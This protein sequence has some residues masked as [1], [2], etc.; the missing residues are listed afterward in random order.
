M[1]LVAE[2]P[3]AA[4]DLDQVRCGDLLW[5]IHCTW[6]DGKAGLVTAATEKQLTVQY[7]PGIGNITNHFIIPVSE[8]A[9]GEWQVRWS[10]DLSDIKKFILPEDSD[11][12]RDIKPENGGESAEKEESRTEVKICVGTGTTD[13]QEI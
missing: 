11:A 2:K 9:A 8:V 4:F 10:A 6:T 1:D 13:L 3:I 5:G 12:G 7:Y